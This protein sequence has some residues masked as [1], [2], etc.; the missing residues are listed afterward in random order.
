M[1]TL[2][3]LALA[4]GI[5]ACAPNAKQA[6]L[7]VAPTEVV[8]CASDFMSEFRVATVPFGE[9]D[10][11][12]WIKKMNQMMGKMLTSWLDSIAN[13]RL[14]TKEQIANAR[15]YTVSVEYGRNG[16]GR[17]GAQRIV[18]DHAYVAVAYVNA[19]GYA[20][21]ASGQ[22]SPKVFDLW[23]GLMIDSI[24]YGH[25]LVYPDGLNKFASF[26]SGAG[27]LNVKARESFL[28]NLNGW[29]AFV[30]LHEVAHGTL[31]HLE[32]ASER[33]PEDC[34][35]WPEAALQKSRE[36]ELD[37]DAE[38]IRLTR[39]LFG[40]SFDVNLFPLN[41][42]LLARHAGIRNL[43][44]G[45]CATHPTAQA[46]FH[47]AA[48]ILALKYGNTGMSLAE[49]IM[50]ATAKTLLNGPMHR[51]LPIITPQTP[52]PA[53]SLMWLRRQEALRAAESP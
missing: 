31:G 16:I 45:S 5:A 21:L 23:Q 51:V 52:I 50:D 11:R 24:A 19:Y 10:E 17:V 13:N 15:K 29:L 14:L 49:P 33:L 44:L 40:S 42:Y 47:A 2:V 1:R 26:I 43:R 46:R 6:T 48:Q 28:R 53:P 25:P 35:R 8:T 18:I 27:G 3:P 41:L 22:I 7:P 20:R 34:M 4:L 32:P 38:A 9:V 30:I 12:A 39:G 37:A 36:R